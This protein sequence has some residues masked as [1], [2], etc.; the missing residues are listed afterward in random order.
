MYPLT[1]RSPTFLDEFDHGLQNREID[2][3]Q[4]FPQARS[5]I[6]T[7]GGE[8]TLGEQGYNLALYVGTEPIAHRRPRFLHIILGIL[9]QLTYINIHARELAHDDVDE[10]L[11]PSREIRPSVFQLRTERSKT[12]KQTFYDVDTKPLEQLGRTVYFV[13]SSRRIIGNT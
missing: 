5:R 12:C 6:R 11:E 1:D 2:R 10:V 7:N 13:L 9:E 3:K 4:T 8:T